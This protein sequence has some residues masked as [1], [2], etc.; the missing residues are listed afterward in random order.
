MKVI[1]INWVTEKSIPQERLS[2]PVLCSVGVQ[3]TEGATSSRL[4]R[5]VTSGNL[6]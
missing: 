6:P 3:A 4:G 5:E 1:A 2:P